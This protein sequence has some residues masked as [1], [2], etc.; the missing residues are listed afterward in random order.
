M[1]YISRK[2]FVNQ[3]NDSNNDSKEYSDEDFLNLDGPLIILGEPGLGKSCLVEEYRKRSGS[4][5]YNASDLS[6]YSSVESGNNDVKIIID[7]LDEVT[8]YSQYES[9]QVWSKISHLEKPNFIITCRSVDWKSTYEDRIKKRWGCELTIGILQRFS[10]AD[11]IEFITTKYTNITPQ[12]F[13]SKSVKC[14][15]EEDMIYNPLILKM[16]IEVV[17]E[18]GWPDSK[19]KLYNDFCEILVE[20]SNLIHLDMGSDDRPS[21]QKLI[22][23]CG[24]IFSQLILSGIGG[25]HIG[26]QNTSLPSLK[27]LANE[28]YQLKT[29]KYAVSTKLFNIVSSITIEP[30]HRTIA[31]YLAGKWISYFL[32][33]PISPRRLNTIFYGSHRI[34]PSSLRGLYAHLTTFLAL[35]NKDLV[36]GLI[37]RD[38]YG[39]LIYADASELNASQL[40]HLLL[41]LEYLNDK[42]PWFHISNRGIKTQRNISEPEVYNEIVKIIQGPSR[43]IICL[44]L[45]AIQVDLF[46]DSIYQK[47]EKFILDKTKS[48][49]ERDAAIGALLASEKYDNWQKIISKLQ[50]YGGDFNSLCLAIDIIQDKSFTFSGNDIANILIKIDFLNGKDD[51]IPV[52]GIGHGIE[53]NLSSEQLE[54]ALHTISE[55]TYENHNSS[56]GEWVF[57]FTKRYLELVPNLDAEKLWSWIKGLENMSPHDHSAWDE[58]SLNYFQENKGLKYIIQKLALRDSNNTLM[59]VHEIKNL[60][61]GLSFSE[62]DIIKHLDDLFKE[63]IKDKNWSNCYIGLVR[64]SSSGEVLKL[65]RIHAE[66]NNLLKEYLTSLEKPA[67]ND[68]ARKSQ[69]REEK[70]KREKEEE[71]LKRHK[72]YDSA[73]IEIKSGTNFGQIHRISCAY[74]GECFSKI[75]GNSS[76]ERVEELAGKQNVLI[77]L[78]GLNSFIK[79]CEDIPSVYKICEAHALNKSYLHESILLAYGIILLERNEL[80]HQ[81]KEILFSILASCRWELFRENFEI[82]NLELYLRDIV[83]GNNKTKK[84]FLRILIESQLGAKVDHVRG[85]CEIARDEIFYDILEDLS[86]AWLNKFSSVSFNPLKEILSIAIKHAPERLKKI[87]RGKIKADKWEREEIKGLWMGAAFIVDYEFSQKTLKTYIEDKKETIWYLKYLVSYCESNINIL[88][89]EQSYFLITLF[90]SLWPPVD[91]PSSGSGNKNARQASDFIRQQI[92]NLSNNYSD[93]GIKKLGDLVNYS[94]LE[95]YQNLIKNLHYNQ[96]T[97]KANEEIKIVTLHGVR[98][99][100]MQSEPSDHEDLQA[101]VF[102]QLVR[103]QN[104]LRSGNNTRITKF[105]KLEDEPRVENHCRDLI[106]DELSHYL[107]SF[108]VSCGREGDVVDDKRCDILCSH[109]LLKLPIEIK[110]QWHKDVWTAHYQQLANYQKDGRVGGRGIYCVLWFGTNTSQNRAIKKPKNLLTPTTPSEMLDLL[111]K[112]LDEEKTKILVLDLSKLS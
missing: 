96:K 42:D 56:I 57:K 109:S 28:E 7:G 54:T 73:Q 84:E 67:E 68:W 11:V 53:K 34:V 76:L 103:L 95:Q 72:C 99:I 51:E 93:E 58:F 33:K 64:S 98:K 15:V 63:E 16:F 105:W 108:N 90:G 112:D 92:Q 20:E 1:N 27:D 60:S 111:N 110:G 69:E 21:N 70:S 14:G 106:I 12:T 59:T 2:I 25:I 43:Q 19:H 101:V 75:S 4:S 30:F 5:I 78:E 89:I 31:E 29:L 44:V 47:L 83:F 6:I 50:E 65:V 52:F 37:E 32:E 49:I 82:R 40:R 61:I 87:I 24:F 94:G 86:I 18:G 97:K 62:E 71:K 80:H 46:P 81:P 79:K 35:E 88:S 3:N 66:Q 55:N 41:C 22:E 85:L 100:L 104:Y 107:N 26:T 36:N 10:D 74:L 13:L 48:F 45:E 77:A 23:T 9:N 38:P 102:D 91:M 39:I 17:K 8:A